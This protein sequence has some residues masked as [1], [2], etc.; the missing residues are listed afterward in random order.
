MSAFE[1]VQAPPPDA[2]FGVGEKY[3]A[4]PLPRKYTLT[5]GVYRTE[6]AKPYVFEAVS[7]AEDIIAHKYS[8]D[9]L[10]MKGYQP[11]VDGARQLL[12]GDE[13][14]AKYGQQIASVQSCAG[15]GALYLTARFCLKNIKVPKVLLANPSW[16]NYK[17]IFADHEIGFFP[18][19][20]SEHELNME[21]ILETL[22]K[23]PEGSLVVLQVIASNPSGTDPTR[24]QWNQIFDVVGKKKHIICFDFAYAG[25]ASGSI[26]E[27]SQIVREYAKLERNFF[28]SFSFSKCMGLYGERIGCLHAFCGSKDEASAVAGNLARI[29][30]STWSVCPQN[31][32]YIAHE[33]MTNPELKKLWFDELKAISKRIAD[34]RVKFCQLLE[35]KTG[36]DWKFLIMQHGMFAYTFLT[37]EQVDKLY[38]Q[39]VFIPTSGRVTVPLL[40]SENIEFVADAFANA[41]K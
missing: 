11:F 18:W 29:G 32:S 28:V 24:E 4:S 17:L 25:F 22:N 10:P 40:N 34:L 41:L 21:G 6:D 15:T 2:I 23:E 5:V 39:G 38:Q 26:E 30:R 31:G 12:W 33:V 7:K 1:K 8:K 13:I 19:L 9:Y 37:P 20:N 36:K 16:P 14:L 35:D 3:N 27:D